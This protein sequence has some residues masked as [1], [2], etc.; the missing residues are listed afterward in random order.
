MQNRLVPI[1]Q[2]VYWGRVLHFQSGSRLKGGLPIL[3]RHYSEGTTSLATATKEEISEELCALSSLLE[4]GCDT[5]HIAH[6]P[7]APAT[8]RL[9]DTAK[10]MK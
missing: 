8:K 2:R 5:C 6:S 9:R 1:T 3:E 7:R 10:L 4:A